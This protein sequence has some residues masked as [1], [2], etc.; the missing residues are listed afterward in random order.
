MMDWCLHPVEISRFLVHNSLFY[1]ALHSKLAVQTFTLNAAMPTVRLSD[2]QVR[3]YINAETVFREWQRAREEAKTVRGGMVWREQDGRRYLIRTSPTGAQKSLGPA[4]DDNE[5]IY[6]RFTTRKRQ[7]EDRVAKLGAQLDEH[8]RLNKALRV[9]R[10]PAVVVD[11]LNA[12]DAAGIGD[13]FTT[14]G[15]HA[16]YAYEAAAGVRVEEGALATNDIDLFFDAQRHMQLLTELRLQRTTLTGIL[17]RVDKSFRV[18]ADMKQTAVNDQGF[19]IDIIRREHKN[20]DPHPMAL[21]DVELDE[22]ALW[23]VQVSTGDQIQSAPGFAQMVVSANGEMALMRTIDPQAFVNIK[24][25][26]SQSRD[27]DRL[28]APRDASQ[29]NIVAELL[30]E[31]AILSQLRERAAAPEEAEVHPS[32]A[33]RGA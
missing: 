2:S 4:S 5:R 24:R 13:H 21:A 17:R 10:V 15:T 9:G 3:Q 8:R 20:R 25:R 23:A 19:E 22:D 11:T 12:L 29:A 28:K 6:E 1:K 30:D 14:V 33:P 7:L 31:G 16:I 26:L 18:R 32:E 27:R